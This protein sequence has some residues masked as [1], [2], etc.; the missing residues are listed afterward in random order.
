MALGAL[1]GRLS[2]GVA[3]M[4]QQ[5]TVAWCAVNGPI[6]A[7]DETRPLTQNSPKCETPHTLLYQFSDS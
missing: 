1:N 6:S 5:V 3:D 2:E 4:P 7:R